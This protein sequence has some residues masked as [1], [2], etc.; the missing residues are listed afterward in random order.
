MIYQNMIGR[1]LKMFDIQA[2]MK[3]DDKLQKANIKIC[4]QQVAGSSPITS[5][6]KCRYGGNEK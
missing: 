4:N 3:E 1:K 6:K 5:S 2:F